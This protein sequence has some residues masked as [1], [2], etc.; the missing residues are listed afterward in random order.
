MNRPP[1]RFDSGG[2][3]DLHKLVRQAGLKIDSSAG[4][5]PATEV[6]TLKGAYTYVR[7]HRH[8]PAKRRLKPLR[9]IV[10]LAAA[11]ARVWTHNFLG[12]SRGL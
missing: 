2:S 7:A 5:A 12:V 3:R 6:A 4:N 1:L 9:D 8:E 10:R 11:V